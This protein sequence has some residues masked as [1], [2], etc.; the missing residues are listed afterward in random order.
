MH[1]VTIKLR[2]RRSV[3]TVTDYSNELLRR[4][5]VDEVMGLYAKD[6]E[7]AKVAIDGPCI[8]TASVVTYKGQVA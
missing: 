2:T 7:A 4:D 8:M 5:A 1:K 3:W 6:I